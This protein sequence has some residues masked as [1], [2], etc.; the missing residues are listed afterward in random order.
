M[1][2]NK[3]FPII[4]LFFVCFI[5]FQITLSAQ[6]N[7]GK[8]VI[9]LHGGAGGF[10]KDATDSLK[11]A[12]LNSLSEA[13]SIGKN[14]LENGGSSLDAVEKVINYL[15]DNSLFNAGKGGVFT[16]EGKHELDASIMF[17]KDLSTGAVA[18]VTIIKN[19]ISLA[20][21]VMEKTGHVLFAGKGADELGLKLGVPVVHNSYFHTEDQYYNWLRSNLPKQPGETV[22]CVALDKQGNI[23]AGTSTGGRQNKMPGR[24]GDS[25]LINAGTFADN[26]TCGVS[27]TGIGELFIRY[28]VAYRISALMEFKGYSLKQACEEVMYKVLPEGAGGIIAV[29]KEGNYEMVFTTPVMF[30]AVANSNGIFKAEIWK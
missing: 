1:N 30:R 17:G 16:S 9:V 23:A 29:D 14:I 5:T 2:K 10:P 12:Y 15:E 3:F 6:Q 19:P 4:I 11:N 20:R 24:V 28:T 22:G 7:E 13:L 8:Y 18:G 21:L 25:P 26:K 27:A